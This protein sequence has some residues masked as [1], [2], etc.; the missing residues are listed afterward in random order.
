MEFFLWLFLKELVYETPVEKP[1]DLV[2]R[3][4]EVA[5]CV[6]DT[7]GIFE[8]VRNSM[9]CRCQTCLDDPEK[10]LR[11]SCRLKIWYA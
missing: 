5:G 1:E 11:I 9:Q 3:I 6:R 10:T 7:P 4:I 2:G 8:K